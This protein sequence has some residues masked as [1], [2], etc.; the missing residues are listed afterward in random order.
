MPI[1]YAGF[2]ALAAALASLAVWSRRSLAVRAGA[3]ALL[4]MTL[5]VAYFA[6]SD[7]LSRPKPA[8]LELRRLNVEEADVLAAA[9]RE[10][11]GIYLWLKLPGFS[12]P[13]YYVMP[14]NRRLAEELQ[15]AM[16]EADREGAGL[17]MRLPFEPSLETRDVPRFYPLPQPKLPDKSYPPIMDYKHPSLTI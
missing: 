10:D 8:A 6:Y 5:G 9:L 7:L 12:E 11:E 14:W 16:R 4:A 17:R 15:E 1:L 3:V 13:R 2:A